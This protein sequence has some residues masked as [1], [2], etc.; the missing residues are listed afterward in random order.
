MKRAIFLCVLLLP[1]LGVTQ[2]DSID[3]PDGS[4][5]L[6]EEI[7]AFIAE[8]E[9]LAIIENDV[10]VA[11]L[12]DPLTYRGEVQGYRE[13]SYGNPPFH[14][15][16]RCAL[17]SQAY[18]GESYAT[19]FTRIGILDELSSRPETISATLQVIDD[20]CAIDKFAERLQRNLVKG[21]PNL[22]M[23]YVERS[24]YLAAWNVAVWSF[25]RCGV[26]GG[27]CDQPTYLNIRVLKANKILPNYGDKDSVQPLQTWQSRHLPRIATTNRQNCVNYF[28]NTYLVEAL[29][30]I[31]KQEE[32]EAEQQRQAQLKQQA[33]ERQRAE[34]DNR[35]RDTENR[36]K[37]ALEAAVKKRDML[38]QE[39]E[40]PTSE[41]IVWGQESSGSGGASASD[42][43]EWFNKVNI[44]Y[45]DKR[46]EATTTP[47]FVAPKKGE[48]EPT[49]EYRARVSELKRS[50]EK[51]ALDAIAEQERK[52]TET[53]VSA[54]GTVS[55]KPRVLRVQYN[56]DREIFTGAVGNGGITVDFQV[57][58]PL[59]EAKAKKAE[60]VD[61]SP[62]V[63]FRFDGKT[64]QPVSMVL[65]ANDTAYE[66]TLDNSK[67]DFLFSQ[68]SADLYLAQSQQAKVAAE[69]AK[70]EK[71]R[72]HAKSFPYF[73]FITCEMNGSSLPL[74]TCLKTNGRIDVTTASGSK[75]YGLRDVMGQND[76][77]V[78]LT[79]SFRVYGESGSSAPK[80]GNMKIEIFSQVPYRLLKTISIFGP[81]DIGAITN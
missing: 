73:A 44:A 81:S 80:F 60:L 75:T 35:A 64:L 23:C 57:S 38:I 68:A 53:L 63:V 10:F 2:D 55:G 1:I 9:E 13:A 26:Y 8:G 71:R 72:L 66:F 77:K 30:T 48:F 76:L 29:A 69:S 24:D 28:T 43:V 37:A 7:A 14:K 4:A 45:Q 70:E 16:E 47:A 74:M 49:S 50:Y 40:I 27:S 65:Q 46:R 34:A 62:W 22:L 15:K 31:G 79:Q 5:A 18:S 32:F 39:I 6:L 56:A 25:G 21:P 54:I 52:T 78:D 36:A 17:T 67:W 20:Y 19:R 61:S 58:V 59:N 3:I 12:P 51:S 41:K 33:R 11:S 42:Q